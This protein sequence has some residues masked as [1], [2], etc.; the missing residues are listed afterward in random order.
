MSNQHTIA[1]KVSC[2]GVGLHSGTP[3]QLTLQPA[4]AG[5][6]IVFVRTDLATP[7][8]IPARPE[9]VTDTRLAT[10]LGRGDATVGT[11]EHL[12]AALRGLGI[13]N[14]R[15]EIDGPE[16]PVMDGSAASFVFLVRVAGIFEQG[17]PR[18]TLRV[19]KPVEVR[20]GDRWARLEPG[21]GL[22]VSYAVDFDH[23]AIGKQALRG[24]ELT[25]ESF[26]AELC[27]ARTFGFLRDVQALWK[28]G[29]GK[30]G[31][32]DNAVLLDDQEVMNRE[33]LRWPDEFVRHKA[34]DLVGD[35]SLLGVELEGH[36]RV[37]K[38]GHALHQ[39][40][41]AEVL[42]EAGGREPRRERSRS[43]LGELVPAPIA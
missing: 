30:G 24:L 21:R 5:T 28:M 8:E 33:G 38:G 26:E 2:T 41:V 6:G 22:R 36:V 13:D 1:E 27:R 3:V 19:R 14:V 42:R 20:D 23:P 39:A 16:V 7:V 35:L 32:L 29:L 4:R 18:R 40:L 10:T 25:P 31:S 43:G 17:A 12:L 11:I 15:V 34:L 37:H 9:Y